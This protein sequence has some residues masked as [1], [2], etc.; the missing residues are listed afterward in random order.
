MTIIEKVEGV[1]K[2]ITLDNETVPYDL[3]S[4]DGDSDTYIVYDYY[5][6]PKF[7]GD[8][9]YSKKE[10]NVTVNICSQSYNQSLYDEVEKKF[11]ENGFLYL[12]GGNTGKNNDFPQTRQ[13][14]KEFKILLEV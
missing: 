5:E 13:T 6:I 10:Y 2:E 3:S 14:Y 9:K 8:G 12:N 1:L 7:L 11:I 4:Y